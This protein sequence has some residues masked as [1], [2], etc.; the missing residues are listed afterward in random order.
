MTET[1]VYQKLS[2][3]QITDATRR[4]VD[5][6]R[7]SEKE[8]LLR[9]LLLRAQ[10]VGRAQDDGKLDSNQVTTEKNLIARDLLIY[11]QQLGE[12]D[13]FAAYN[14]VPHTRQ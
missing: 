5:D 13:L 12:Q 9:V 1:P 8:Y 4:S 7:F 2:L 14:I 10:L 6:P 11:T 3:E